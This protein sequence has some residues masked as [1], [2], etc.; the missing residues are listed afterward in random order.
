M[1]ICNKEIQAKVNSK[2]RK[3]QYTVKLFDYSYLAHLKVLWQTQNVC[4]TVQFLLRGGDLT[5]GFFA[6][7]VRGGF[8]LKGL[9]HRG[10]YFQNVTVFYGVVLE[11]AD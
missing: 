8:Y 11:C 7:R 6:L 10:A 9:L 1:S 2:G 4:V 5:E 3:Q